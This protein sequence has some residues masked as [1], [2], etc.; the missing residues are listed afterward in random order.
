MKRIKDIPD[1]IWALAFGC[2]RGDRE[3]VQGVFMLA[4]GGGTLRPVA[5]ETGRSVGK[6][7]R[8]RKLFRE[9]LEA[10]REEKTENS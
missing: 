6:L 3:T 10:Y 5:E 7:R 1:D 2:F 8:S 9:V 4:F